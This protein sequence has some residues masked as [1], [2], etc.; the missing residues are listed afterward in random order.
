MPWN[1]LSVVVQR[2]NLVEAMLEG[3]EPVVAICRR[4]GVSRQTA[5]KFLRRFRADGGAGLNN[6]L[7]G[8]SHPPALQALRWSKWVLRLRKSEPTWGARKLLWLLR[9]KGARRFLPAERTVQRW[10]KKAG[11]IRKQRSIRRQVRPM[12]QRRGRCAR[13]SNEVWTIDLKG[14]FRTGNRTKIEPLTVRDLWSK[15]VLW[16]RQLAP[17]DGAGVRWV[18]QRL[19]SRYGRPGVIRCDLGAPF[20][21]DGPHGFTRLSLW[22]WRLGI[23]VEFVRR[24]SINNNAHEQMHRVMKAELVIAR[25]AAEQARCLE[26]W[27]RRYN[28]HRPHDGLGGRTPASVY[29]PRAGPRLPV[30]RKPRY[31]RHYLVK[32]VQRDGLITL[33]GWRGSIGRAFGGLHVGLAPAGNR[34]YRVYFASL[35]LGMLDLNRT[36]KLKIAAF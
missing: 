12:R 22:W 27:R 28:R 16:A 24:G 34:R 31:P 13:R 18:C 33:P 10:I 21:G 14:W 8:P 15:Y 30:W 35:Y 9:Q 1:N 20:F 36:A 26:R 19:F 32:H 17:R 11:L 29:R 23:R 4:F 25:T 7:A 5:Y 2:R 3:A 6:C